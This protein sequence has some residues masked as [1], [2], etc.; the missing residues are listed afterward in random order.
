MTSKSGGKASRRRFFGNSL[1][2]R[3]STKRVLRLSRCRGRDWRTRSVEI[4][5]VQRRITS[6][7]S[8]QRS[9]GF[10]KNETPSDA[11]A[12]EWSERE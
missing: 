8:S 6:G 9:C 3:T 4:M 2:E 7:C 12:W 10:V 1:T 5:E 11:A